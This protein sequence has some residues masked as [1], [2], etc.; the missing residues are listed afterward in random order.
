MQRTPGRCKTEYGSMS[1]APK[2]T[3]FVQSSRSPSAERKETGWPV[4]IGTATVSSLRSSAA[5][6]AAVRS[7]RA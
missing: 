6:A 7:L 4:M 2:I 3:K 1:S 5:A